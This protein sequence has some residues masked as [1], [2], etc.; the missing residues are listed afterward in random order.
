MNM[1]LNRR[2]AVGRACLAVLGAIGLT[3]AAGRADA[4]VR[5]SRRAYRT[6]TIDRVINDQQVSVLGGRGS[7]PLEGVPA[8]WQPLIGDQV[9]VGPSPLLKRTSAQQLRHWVMRPA[10]PQDLHPGRRL[11]GPSGPMI[12]EVT[13]IAPTVVSLRG[14]RDTRVRQLKV[15]VTVRRSSDGRERVLA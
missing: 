10:A 11:G 5:R 3:G 7:L 6:S 1:Q 9:A 8:G 13:T 2:S 12:T 15:A 4:S 14:Q